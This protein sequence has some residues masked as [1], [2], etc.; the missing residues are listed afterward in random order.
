MEDKLCMN[1]IYK[2]L[3]SETPR[4]WKSIR[5][6]MIAAGV[7]GAALIA[8]PPEQTDWLLKPTWVPD[9]LFGIMTTIGTTGTVLA[10]L[11]KKDPDAA[12]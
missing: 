11:T 12:P 10:S 2:R 6:W 7:L 1:S 8:L 9:H 5:K 4:F 3:R